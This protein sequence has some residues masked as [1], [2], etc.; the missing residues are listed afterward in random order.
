MRQPTHNTNP[1]VHVGIE[2]DVAEENLVTNVVEQ[3][4]IKLQ[5]GWRQLVHIREPVTHRTPKQTVR[6]RSGPMGTGLWD[7]VLVGLNPDSNLLPLSWP[8]EA[9]QAKTD[10]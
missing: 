3:H 2:T 5:N 9:W 1:G 10:N 4:L 7:Q 6:M 8:Q